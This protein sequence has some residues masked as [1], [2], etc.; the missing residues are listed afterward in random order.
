VPPSQISE[1]YGQRERDQNQKDFSRTALPF[2]FVV[3]QVIEIA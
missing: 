1:A 2:F 3:K